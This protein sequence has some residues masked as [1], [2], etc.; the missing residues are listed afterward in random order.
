MS[1]KLTIKETLEKYTNEN[2]FAWGVNTALDAI[3][4][5]LQFDLSAENGEFIINSWVYKQPTSKQIRE[6]YLRQKTIAEFLEFIKNNK[7]WFIKFLF[8][9]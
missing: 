9:K 1:S 2:G 4:P 3:K 7:I 5:D 6:E 8:K